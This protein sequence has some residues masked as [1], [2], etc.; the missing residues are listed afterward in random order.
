MP[1][2]FPSIL[3]KLIYLMIIAGMKL[4]ANALIHEFTS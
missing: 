3:E 1:S 4:C 2:P